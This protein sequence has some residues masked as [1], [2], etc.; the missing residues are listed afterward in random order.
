VTCDEILRIS[1]ATFFASVTAMTMAQTIVPAENDVDAS[2]E[3]AVTAAP[4]APDF[5]RNDP[6]IPAA[7]SMN[8][9][10]G[11]PRDIG[12]KPPYATCPGD[13]MTGQMPA[14]CRRWAE[15]ADVL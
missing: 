10:E 6:Q 1:V 5:A 4:V 9:L 15:I 8:V 3:S 13:F 12:G 11:V 14:G 2:R 7:A